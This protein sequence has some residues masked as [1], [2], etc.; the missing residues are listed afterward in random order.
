MAASSST[1][2][3]VQLAEPVE[4]ADTVPEDEGEELDLLPLSGRLHLVEVRSAHFVLCDTV[5][6][7]RVDLPA[8]TWDLAF[9]DSGDM[10]KLLFCPD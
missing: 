9:E 6:F 1:S 4:T 3:S 10:A 5:T 8:G 2:S 7:E